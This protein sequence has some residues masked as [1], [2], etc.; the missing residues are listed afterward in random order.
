M[1]SFAYCFI[2]KTL[3]FIIKDSYLLVYHLLV[4]D[5]LNVDM[6]PDIK[7]NNV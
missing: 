4:F 7:V 3:T 6:L 1:S 5:S 2:G